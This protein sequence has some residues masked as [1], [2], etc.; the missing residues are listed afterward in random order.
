MVVGFTT[1]MAK[2]KL[3]AT[4]GKV[5]LGSV[6]EFGINEFA[7]PCGF[8]QTDLAHVDPAV[9]TVGQLIAIEAIGDRFVADITNRF[10]AACRS[11]GI[12]CLC[13]S[14]VVDVAMGALLR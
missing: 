8:G 13:A 2:N 3:G 1:G 5:G 9:V 12:E 4:N 6:G 14:D 7:R 10:V 11:F